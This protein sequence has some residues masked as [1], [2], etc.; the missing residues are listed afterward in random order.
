MQIR[1]QYNKISLKNLDSQLKI[2]QNALPI[3]T[4]KE[5]ALRLHVQNIRKAINVLEEKIEKKKIEMESYMEMW[6]EFEF[7]LISIEDMVLTKHNIAGI[8][9]QKLN[10]VQFSEKAYL[11]TVYPAWY[12]VGII[13]LKLLLSMVIQVEVEQKNLTA[14]ENARRKTT[15]KVNL[16]EKMQIPTYQ[17][18]I[19]K[20]KRYLENEDH[21]AMSAQK[22]LKSKLWQLNNE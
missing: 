21:I 4:S 2:R 10:E 13:D 19:L 11:R 9:I 3:L 20:I 14:L 1:F 8:Y 22:I 18:A 15:Q 5:S 16:Y 12:D 17:D 7:S 6:N